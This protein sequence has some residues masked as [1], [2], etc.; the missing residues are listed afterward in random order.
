MPGM[1]TVSAMACVR[2]VTVRAAMVVMACMIVTSVV[3]T[4]ARLLMS[5]MIVVMVVV[6]QVIW[7]ARWSVIM[8]VHV[9]PTR[10][11]L[12]RR[13]GGGR[14]T[15]VIVMTIEGAYRLVG[16]VVFGVIH[17]PGPYFL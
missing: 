17:V 10:I 16:V 15:L 8:M 11:V 5:S 1:A 4:H 7:L 3:L 14:L 9:I 12:L 13:A 6:L 2:I